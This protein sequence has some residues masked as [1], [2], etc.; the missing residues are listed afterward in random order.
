MVI[1]NH[2]FQLL[3][4]LN[5]PLL[6]DVCIHMQFAKDDLK[7]FPMSKD[8]LF[9]DI[10]FI[11]IRWEEDLIKGFSLEHEAFGQCFINFKKIE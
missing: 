9:G 6:I 1:K 10:G 3:F 4:S 7:L 2:T 11:H 8:L 5:L